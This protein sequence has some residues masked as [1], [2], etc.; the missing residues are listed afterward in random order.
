MDTVFINIS[1]AQQAVSINASNSLESVS[2]QAKEVLGKDGLTAYEVAVANGFTGNVAAWLL[3]LRG[4]IGGVFVFTQSTPLAVWNM[5]HNLGY[6]PNVSVV[7]SSGQKVYGDT[8]YVDINNVQATFSGA[9]SG[10]AY[11]S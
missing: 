6:Y 4:A 1:E 5:N 8:R 2:I 7:D 10:N 9:F 11:L 3:S